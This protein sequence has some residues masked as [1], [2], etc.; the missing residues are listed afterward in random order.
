MLPLTNRSLSVVLFLGKTFFGT[1][2][3]YL[4]SERERS[5]ETVQWNHPTIQKLARLIKNRYG[6]DLSYRALKDLTEDERI[7]ACSH[8]HALSIHLHGEAVG[9][10]YVS[11]SHH[12]CADSL[13]ALKEVVS[14]VMEFTLQSSNHLE[15]INLLEHQ[16][17]QQNETNII[18]MIR[19]NRTT[20]AF[21]NTKNYSEDMG[22]NTPVLIEANSHDDILKMAVEIHERSQRYAFIQFDQLSDSARLNSS[23]L[24]GMGR[25]SLFIPDLV[26]LTS[27]ETLTLIHFINTSTSSDCPQ[28]IVGTLLRS[29]QLMQMD[30]I[31]KN[32]Y[33]LLNT[34]VFRLQ[35]PFGSFARNDLNQF[36]ANTFTPQAPLELI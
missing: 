23:E 5:G 22:P 32:L 4:L 34:A 27:A 6:C 35:K 17:G 19:P 30:S 7:K 2:L 10:V 36:F 1:S 11:N 13:K 12:L 24:H 16:L 8:S 33:T 29:E 3:A 31:H 15:I 21:L 18:K 28:I 26:E 9:V 14:T 20:N 25:I